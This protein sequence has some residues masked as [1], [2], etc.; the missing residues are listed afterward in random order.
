VAKQSRLLERVRS[1]LR[2]KHYSYRTEETYSQWIYRFILF[3]HERHPEDMGAPEIEQYLTHIAVER[4][5]AASTQNQA[6][7]AL[8]FLYVDVLRR[9]LEKL[10]DIAPARR[11]KR[12]PEVFTRKEVK[13]ILQRIEGLHW[14][15]AFLLYGAGLRLMECVRLRI[16]DIDFGYKQIVVRSGKGN[17][18]R[19]TMLP[20]GAIDPLT[21]QITR[22]RDV[23]VQDLSGGYGAVYLPHAL[24]LKYPSARKDTGW[25]YV[26]PSGQLSKD[27]R[28]RERRRHH[29]DSQSLQR[30]V[31]RAIR[32]SGIVKH[33]SCHTFR[34]SFGTHLLEDGYDIRTVQEL[35]GH[36]D[37]RTTQI[38][39]HVLNRGG[40]GVISPADRLE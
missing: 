5:V 3:H 10:K 6:R 15:M 32:K 34:H 8:L 7:N 24:A 26:F 20:T 17:V 27:P 9:N 18:D 19:R 1:T 14:L 38:Y 28:S 12:L 39:T 23:H 13:S 22:A 21:R 29:K 35:M 16:K 2:R 36:K 33:A 4:N 25:Q 37:V 11:P 40:Q 31:K 30:A